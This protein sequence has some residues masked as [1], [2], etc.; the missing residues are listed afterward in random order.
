MAV[1]QSAGADV[2]EALLVA[3]ANSD[4]TEKVGVVS[5]VVFVCIFGQ[6][7]VLLLAC[8]HVV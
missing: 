6:H 7:L 4:V 2:I 1:E 3:G 5:I 8:L